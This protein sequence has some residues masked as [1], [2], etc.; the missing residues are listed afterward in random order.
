MVPKYLG[1]LQCMTKMLLNYTQKVYKGIE[2]IIGKI[3]D[4][5]HMEGKWDIPDMLKSR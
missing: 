1:H 3:K 5:N 2:L 4:R